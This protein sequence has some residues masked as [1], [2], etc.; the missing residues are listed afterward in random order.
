MSSTST[1]LVRS[2]TAAPS[3][4][5]TASRACSTSK[6][7][8]TTTTPGT[9]T[10]PVN[11]SRTSAVHRKARPRRSA[12]AA[13][14]SSVYFAKYLVTTRMVI[15]ARLIAPGPKFS[16]VGARRSARF[17]VGLLPLLAGPLISLACARPRARGVAEGSRPDRSSILVLPRVRA[18]LDYVWTTT[19]PSSRR[20]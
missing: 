3:A 6:S 1:T 11:S 9:T 12:G 17:R 14:I 15:P 2:P 18:L 8:T 16:L 13:R 10:T 5:Q 4:F 20:T 19:H 7:S